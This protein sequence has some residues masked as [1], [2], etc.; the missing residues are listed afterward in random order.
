[1]MYCTA[2]WMQKSGRQ[3][4]ERREKEKSVVKKKKGMSHVSGAVRFLED[5]Q[6]CCLRA[7]ISSSAPGRFRLLL[8]KARAKVWKEL[9]WEL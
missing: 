6:E 9:Y 3:Q 7:Y 8:I 1:M 2:Y 4:T 5:S